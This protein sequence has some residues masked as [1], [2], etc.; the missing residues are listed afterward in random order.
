[1]HGRDEQVDQGVGDLPLPAVQVGGQQRHHDLVRVGA[2]VAGR[3]GRDPGPPARQHL[4]G[5]VGEQVVRQADRADR[6]ELERLLPD[7]LHADVARLVTDRRERVHP[8][9]LRGVEQRAV[10]PGAGVLFLAS[11]SRP[12]DQRAHPADGLSGYP[13]GDPRGQRLLGLPHCRADDPPDPVTGRR[14]DLL[15]LQVRQQL[16][17]DPAGLPLLL[18]HVRG[19][20]LRR[21][22]RVR[23]RALPEPE[24]PPDV[25]PVSLDR[26][27]VPR[28]EPKVRR[29]NVHQPR[30][31]GDSLVRDLA[32]A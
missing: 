29:G 16:H 17:A 18:A 30:D 28:I 32:A 7:G 22:V 1:V 13:A 31:I 25:S 8:G 14:L 21:L 2:Q 11:V 24:V 4:R 19:Q 3:L 12:R 23:D 15:A 26:P 9:H 5:D 27:A 6:A 10:V 20:P